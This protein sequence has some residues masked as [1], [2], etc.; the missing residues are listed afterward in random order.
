[1]SE[2]D[3]KTITQHPAGNDFEPLAAS[4]KPW[5]ESEE[6]LAELPEDIQERIKRGAMLA[7]LWDVISPCRRRSMAQERDIQAHPGLA[8]ERSAL[9]EKSKEVEECELTASDIPRAKRT[10]TDIKM[11][12]EDLRG[13]RK[14]EAALTATLRRKAQSLGLGWPDG[15]AALAPEPDRATTVTATERQASATTIRDEVTAAYRYAKA[16]GMKPPNTKQMGD[17]VQPI[18]AVKGLKASKERIATVA[19]EA[20]FKGERLLNGVKSTC[21][22]FCSES[23][24]KSRTES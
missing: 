23:F 7:V 16:N 11:Q 12:E 24:Q 4:L 3:D 6:K 17:F 2:A 8:L 20:C 15:W 19:S 5:F 21:L 1:M 14:E 18:L 9:W 13:L 22:P 10:M